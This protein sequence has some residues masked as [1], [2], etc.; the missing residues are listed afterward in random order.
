MK[1]LDKYIEFVFA[2][3]LMPVLLKVKSASIIAFQKD[4][5]V[6]NQTFFTSLEKH[7]FPYETDYLCLYENKHSYYVLLYHSDLLRSCFLNIKAKRILQFCNYPVD[8][9]IK[10]MLWY[11]KERYQAFKHNEI[12]FPDE[13]GIFLGYPI[14]DVEGYIMQQGRN[15]LLCGYWKVYSNLYEAVRIFALYKELQREALA[16]YYKNLK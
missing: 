4:K 5:M 7:L 6:S 16:L 1:N 3:I 11:L 14:E 10:Q 9:E 8:G 12:A 15:Y 2:S 13:I